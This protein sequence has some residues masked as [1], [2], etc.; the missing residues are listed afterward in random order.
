MFDL[1][2]NSRNLVVILNDLPDDVVEMYVELNNERVEEL[3]RQSG[4]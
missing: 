2:V 4:V 3:N 1:A